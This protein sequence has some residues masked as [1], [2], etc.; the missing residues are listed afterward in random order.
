MILAFGSGLDAAL[1]EIRQLGFPA[2]IVALP[3]PKPELSYQAHEIGHLLHSLMST[4][5]PHSK[6]ALPVAF[7]YL[8]D[9]IPRPVHGVS[10]LLTR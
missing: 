6:I 10:L 3:K 1:K 8:Q 5:I 7:I 9:I 2:S 4:R